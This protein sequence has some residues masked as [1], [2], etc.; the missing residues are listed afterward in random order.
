[1]TEI[2][3]QTE[4]LISYSEAARILKITRATL[5]AWIQKGLLHPFKIADRRYLHRDQVESMATKV[6]LNKASE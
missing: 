6:E 5:Y 4:D 1:M 2:R 3:L